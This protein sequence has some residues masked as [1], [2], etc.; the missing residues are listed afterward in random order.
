MKWLRS[1]IGYFFAGMIVMTIWGGV[2]TS[3][4]GYVGG[5]L[6]AMLIIGPMWFMNHAMNLTAHNP[7][8]GFVDIGL[9]IAVTGI[10]RDTIKLGTGELTA[11]LPTIAVVVV[12]AIFGGIVAAMVEKDLAKDNK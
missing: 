12:G 1:I 3:D 7:N 8:S 5:I 6:A 9:G 4:F 11:A 10:A 2:I